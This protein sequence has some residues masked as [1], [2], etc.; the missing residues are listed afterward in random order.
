MIDVVF[1][2]QVLASIGDGGEE[3]RDIF[4]FSRRRIDNEDVF[5]K[6]YIPFRKSGSL[7]L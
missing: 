4:P 2:L 1:D 7:L 5:H 6:F 3:R